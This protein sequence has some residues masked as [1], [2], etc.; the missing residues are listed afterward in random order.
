[1]QK[2]LISEMYRLEKTHWWHVAKRKLVTEY[3]KKYSPGS[4]HTVLD[5]GCGTGALLSDLKIFTANLYG[6]DLSNES[7]MFTQK[8]GIERIKRVDFE[9]NLPFRNNF[10]D[11]ITC[12]DVLEHVENDRGLLAEFERIL[13]PGGCLYLTVPAYQFL[14]T[15]WDEVLG[16]KRRY[17]RSGLLKLFKS[18]N[19]S[20]KFETYFYSFL[21]PAVIPFRYLKTIVNNNS[22]DFISF[23]SLLNKI[24]L[25]VCAVERWIIR[26]VKIPFGLSIFVVV[27][28]NEN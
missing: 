3:I 16:H 28:K 4:N 17:R 25:L 8:R 20:V 23:P 24:M 9:K 19:F 27:Q 12:L 15:Y 14:W 11:V 6:A 22:S 5:A 7:I 1:M 13:K 18:L 26:F 21:L 2:K 10:F